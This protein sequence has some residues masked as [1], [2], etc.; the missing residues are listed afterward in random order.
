[1]SAIPRKRS[2]AVKAPPIAIGQKQE[3]MRGLKG[4]GKSPFSCAQLQ[5]LT[6]IA[7]ALFCK[8]I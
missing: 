3:S 6:K 5:P 2:P 7:P 4:A 8:P 1:M